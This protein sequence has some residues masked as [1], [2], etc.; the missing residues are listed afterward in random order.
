MRRRIGILGT[1]A[2]VLAVVGLIALQTVASA[3][4]RTRKA[5]LTG[6]KEVPNPGDTDGTGNARVRINDEKGK[7]CFTLKWQNI[8]APTMA[9][10][11]DGDSETA[12]PIVVTLFMGSEPLPATIDTVKGCAQ[13]E[14]TQENVALL[15]DI[16]RHPRQYYVNIHNG[17]F[18]GGAIR[19][20]LK[21]PKS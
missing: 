15:D 14:P 11:H 16:Q 1:V 8:G 13:L 18:P 3:D 21:K 19:G 9:H 5:R 4:V 6:A 20:Q 2:A 12:G 10:I 17:D 7:V